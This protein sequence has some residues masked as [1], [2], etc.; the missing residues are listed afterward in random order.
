[1][2]TL[3]ERAR[4]IRNDRRLSD[5]RWDYAAGKLLI[6]TVDPMGRWD[7]QVAGPCPSAAAAAAIGL[8][9]GISHGNWDSLR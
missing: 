8:T 6:A 2:T 3:L 9:L 4:A 5:A 7:W 1:M